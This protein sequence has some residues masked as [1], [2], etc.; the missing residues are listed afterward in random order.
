MKTKLRSALPLIAVAVVMAAT[1]FM[2]LRNRQPDYPGIAYS[3]GRIEAQSIDVATRYGGRVNAVT[4]EEGQMVSAGEVIA[5]LDLS[6]L[7]ASLTGAEANVRASEQKKQAAAAG[8]TQAQAA[9]D[10]ANREF[11]RYDRLIKDHAVSESRRDQALNA[12]QAAAAQLDVAEKNLASATEAISVAQAE[13][14]RLKDLLDDQQLRA[15][16]A[17]RVLYRLVEPGEVVGAGGKVVTLLDLRDVYM[18]IFLPASAAGKLRIGADARIMVDALPDKAIPAYVSYVSPEAQFTPR[19]VE[20]RTE[21]EKLTFRVKVRVPERLL[22][23]HIDAVKTGVPGIAYVKTD[24][25]AP[26]P[27]F[28]R[29]DPALL[30]ELKQQP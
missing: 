9:L 11:A 18:S 14:A 4:V 25:A 2:A 12:Q 1:L 5:E 26:W 28:L 27:A 30:D 6:D 20:T 24:P 8:V 29:G 17:G 10:L 21:R 7:A 22:E 3:N 19:Q 16:E 15:P 13:V 23:K